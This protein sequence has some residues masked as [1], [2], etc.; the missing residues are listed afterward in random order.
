MESS[1]IFIPLTAREYSADGQVQYICIFPDSMM[2]ASYTEHTRL[3]LRLIILSRFHG[4]LTSK[5]T[6]R[7]TQNG[8]NASPP[9]RVPLFLRSSNVHSAPESR[10]LSC[11]RYQAQLSR[12]LGRANSMV[13]CTLLWKRMTVYKEK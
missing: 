9:E 10:T 7:E 2:F 5:G 12:Q 4:S 11:K 13:P 6:D 1:Q 8:L 3:S